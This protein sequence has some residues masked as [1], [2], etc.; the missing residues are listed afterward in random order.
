[1]IEIKK[2]KNK[3]QIV[4]KAIKM[5][6]DLCI[7]ITGGDKPHLGSV[8][9]GEIKEKENTLSLKGHKEHFIT[10]IVYNKLRKYYKGNIVVCAG[11]HIDNITKNEID[12]IMSIVDN[13]IDSLIEDFL[14]DAKE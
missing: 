8:T 11:M 2:S 3:I 13:L 4:L 12:D 14:L 9:L 1:M 7:I 5:G 6:D 10:S